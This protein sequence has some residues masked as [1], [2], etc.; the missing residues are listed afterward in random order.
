MLS[1]YRVTLSLTN[2]YIVISATA[3]TYARVHLSKI[4]LNIVNKLVG[5]IYYSDRDGIVAE[6]YL[7]N[8]IINPT[9]R[10]KLKLEH[11]LKKVLYI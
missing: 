10:G 5:R 4:K 2:T 7:R 6:I 3:T 1:K 8:N 11:F 9:E